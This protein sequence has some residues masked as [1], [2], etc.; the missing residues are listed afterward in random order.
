MTSVDGGMDPTTA[1]AGFDRTETAEKAR[2]AEAERQQVITEFPLEDWP[3]LPLERYALG[4]DQVPGRVPYCRLLEFGTPHLG[5]I[6]GGGAAKHIIFRHHSGQWRISP[7]SLRETGPHEAWEQLRDQFVRAFEAVGNKD[8]DAVDGLGLLRYG[9]ALVTKSLATYFPEEFLP[10]YSGT[11]LRGFIRLLGGTPEG[12]AQTWQLNRHLLHLVSRTPAFEGW[13]GQEVM[14]FLYQEFDPRPRQRT[15]WKIAPGERGR[16]W[17]ECLAGGFICV[18]WDELG[19]LGEYGSDTELRR[20]MDGLWPKSS[21]GNSRAARNLLAFRDLEVGDTVVANRGTSEILGVGTVREAYRFDPDRA[22]FRHVLPVEWDTSYAQTL[23]RPQ[24]GWRST[25]ARIS[26]TQFDQISRARSGPASASNARPA[27]G[28]AELTEDVRQVLDALERKKQVIL[29]G[30]PGTGKTR[31]ALGAALAVAGRPEAVDAP[32]EERHRAVRLLLGDGD[33]VVRM[34]TFH[35]SYGYEDFVEGF[36]PGASSQGQGLTLT[37]TDGLFHELCTAAAE[38]PDRTFLLIVDEI[39]R[40]D[41]PRIFGELITLLEPDKRGV[42]LKLP[43]SK[44][45]FSVPENIRIIGTM[46]TADRSISHLDAAVRRRF[47]F[48][49]VEPDPEAVSGTVGPLNLASF[50]ESLNTRVTRHLDADHRIGHAYLLRDGEPISTEEDLAAA[51]HHDVLPLLEDYCLGRPELLHRILGSL[52]DE[53][54]G[55]PSLM[56][57]QDLVTALAAEFTASSSDGDG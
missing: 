26:P 23:P 37:L 57:P 46:N 1:A 25:F 56:P 18:G 21:G 42:P 54:T 12:G 45:M 32:P 8:V 38:H 33:G 44:R 48:L 50:I 29:Y 9:P 24:H 16:L 39:N 6:R 49:P 47:A 13:S 27:V 17:E 53:E 3:K 40:G 19:D 2:R 11:H 51:F 34:V 41:L 43:I 5:S 15:I 7:P 55:S 31:L 28:E 36:K 20:A 4:Q 22:E 52:I 14:R 35:P 30:P 10:V